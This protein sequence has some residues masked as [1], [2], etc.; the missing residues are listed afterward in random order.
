MKNAFRSPASVPR[1]QRGVVLIVALAL[2]LTLSFLAV[3]MFRS[4][5]LEERITGNT[6]EKQHA[7]FAAQS[8]LQY[9]EFWLSTGN[10]G[11]PSACAT[12]STTPQ[13]CTQATTPSQQTL[14]TTEWNTNFGTTFVPPPIVVNGTPTTQMA[15]NQYYA[16]PQFGITYLGPDPGKPGASLYQVT[17]Q[18]FGGNPNAVAV[19]QSVYSVGSGGTCVSCGH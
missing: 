4:L 9:A 11:L 13:V 10:A 2:L 3:G 12:T 1:R 8:A 18:G 7:F 16:D 15:S 6:R 19:V 17:S 5:G 14:A